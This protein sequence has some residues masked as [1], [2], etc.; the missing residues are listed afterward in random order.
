MKFS[1]FSS[2]LHRW[3]LSIYCI[4]LEQSLF[5][6]NYNKHSNQLTK[7]YKSVNDEH[8]QSPGPQA[9]KSCNFNSS[10]HSKSK[11]I[12]V[13]L[14]FSIFPDHFGIPWLF[15]VFQVSGHPDFYL[16]LFFLLYEGDAQLLTLPK[17]YKPLTLLNIVGPH[18]HFW[19]HGGH[20][21]AEIHLTWNPR[22][23]M[24][25]EFRS[26]NQCHSATDCRT[27]LTS[28][29]WIHYGSAEVVE[30][31]NS[32][33]G[34]CIMG[35]VIKAQNSWHDVDQPQVSYKKT[36]SQMPTFPVGLMV[37]LK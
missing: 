27:L 24:V 28:G 4:A 1:D 35:L 8:I 29:V 18:W 13:S 15:Q 21:M 26:L 14:T 2:S 20:T 30:V 16:P 25:P 31:L 6:V 10:A 23:G 37:I 11:Q 5:H 34:R 9:A 32:F 33:A 22:L 12:S 17:V 19:V 3:R 36:A 7:S